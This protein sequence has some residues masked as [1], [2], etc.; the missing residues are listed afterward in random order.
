MELNRILLE[1][2]TWISKVNFDYEKNYYRSNELKPLSCKNYLELP[3]SEFY[4]LIAKRSNYLKNNNIE[5]LNEEDVTNLGKLIWSEPED[6]VFDGGAEAYAQGLYDISECPPWDTWIAKGQDFIEFKHL[7]NAIIS[8]LP[9][10]HF[11]KFYSGKSVSIMDNMDWIM[12]LNNSN[13]FV[14]TL[15][16]KPNNLIFEE[17]P[18]KWHSSEQLEINDKRWV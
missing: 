11:N 3:N 12:K 10:E 13:Y 2:I 17:Q 5:I 18:I 15:I 6:S 1:T 8:W 16:G 4:K 7:G 14:Q 9:N